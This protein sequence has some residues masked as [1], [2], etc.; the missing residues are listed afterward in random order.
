MKK[1]DH[2]KEVEV[3]DQWLRAYRYTP[4]HAKLTPVRSLVA[5][6]IA[7]GLSDKEISHFLGVASSTVKAHNTQILKSF[8]L[9]RRAQVVRYMLESGQFAPEAAAQL[10][11][12]RHNGFEKEES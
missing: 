11:S 2:V 7:C 4:L 8:G 6:L 5:Q 9:L 12:G 1:A 3:Q 10:L